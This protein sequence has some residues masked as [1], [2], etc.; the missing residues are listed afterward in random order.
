M[1]EWPPLSTFGPAPR[2]GVVV[3]GAVR[4]ACLGLPF[5]DVDW[6]VDDPHSAADDLARRVGGTYFALDAAR[7]HWRVVAGTATVDLVPVSGSLL[8]NLRARDFTIDAMAVGLDGGIDPLGGRRDL[9]RRTLVACTPTALRDDPIRGLRG[10]RLAALL[11][12]RWDPATRAQAAA[13][14]ADLNAGRLAMPSPERIRDEFLAILRSPRPGTALADA[15]SVGWLSVIAP[16]LVAGA[17]VS[18]GSLH[19]L[20]VLEHQ[21]ETVE[22]L[23]TAFPDA[24]DAER[25]A[26]L[27]HDAGKTWCRTEGHPG[28]PRF[29]GHAEEGAR[30]VRAWCAALR[31]PTST[32]DRAARLVADHM[33]P[34]PTTERAARRFVH[35]RRDLLPSLLRVMLADREAARGR[36]A[37]RAGRDRYRSAVSRVLAVLEAA[38]AAPERYLTGRDVMAILGVSPGP[39]VGRALAFL[40]ESSAVGDVRDHDEA[41]EA[42]RTWFAAQTDGAV[43]PGPRRRTQA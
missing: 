28:P 3:G 6:L 30:R 37:T 29:H 16:D 10:V 19:H 4:D 2:G 38:P 41:V 36:A 26:A 31:I 8:A 43:S 39:V 17:G 42:V 1:E 20:D 22:R 11:A 24:D 25:L 13:V 35:R 21:L 18:Q 7:G 33:V 14:A 23:A 9:A 5:S 32:S 34:L 27:W 12:L 40:D 15:H